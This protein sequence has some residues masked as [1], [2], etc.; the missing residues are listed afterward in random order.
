MSSEFI[1]RKEV[2]SFSVED[3][4]TITS[5]SYAVDSQ[6]LMIEFTSGSTLIHQNV[7]IGIYLDLM[8]AKSIGGYY[9]NNVRDVYESQQV[10]EP[11]T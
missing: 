9:N 2:R 10:E 11:T 1:T 8:R 4:D 6:D 5:V 7:P 3:S